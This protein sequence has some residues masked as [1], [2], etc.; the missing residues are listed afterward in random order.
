MPVKYPSPQGQFF[1]THQRQLLFQRQPSAVGELGPSVTW[2]QGPQYS[3]IGDC[4]Y[5]HYLEREEK[6]RSN[7]KQ[8]FLERMF[9]KYLYI[10]DL[11]NVSLSD[12]DK[13]KYIPFSICA[14]YSPS[15]HKNATFLKTNRNTSKENSQVILNMMVNQSSDFQTLASRAVVC[16]G[17]MFSGG[18]NAANQAPHTKTIA[19]E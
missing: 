6:E 5:L 13:P 10:Q 2:R 7:P 8:H 18:T 16:A 9:I 11:E 15:H 17:G 12:S 4:H 19:P 14:L 3:I 1:P